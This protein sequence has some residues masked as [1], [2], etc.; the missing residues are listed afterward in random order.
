MLAADGADHILM[1]AD[2]SVHL[3]EAHGIHIDLAVGIADQL[4]GT[5]TCLA[6]LAV[7][8]GIAEACHVTG[9][10]PGL[11]IHDD[12]CIQTHIIGAFLHKLL[13]PCLFDIILELDAQRT[14]IP[15]VCQTAVHLTAGIH[16]AAV[17]AEIDDHIKGLFAVFHIL[18]P[19][20]EVFLQRFS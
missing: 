19:P 13:H 3:V 6:G 9:G 7:Q 12:G 11:G 1:L 17:F 5:V 8:Q 2:K 18:K 16:K 15:A 14:V 10:D 4:I 20:N